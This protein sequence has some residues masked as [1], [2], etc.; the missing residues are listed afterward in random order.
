MQ[1]WLR[2]NNSENGPYTKEA[3]I[4]HGLQTSDL[5]RLDGESIWKPL[6]QFHELQGAI[7]NSPK[8]KYKFTADKQL[9]EIKGDP[10]EGQNLKE[11]TPDKA[12]DKSPDKTP[13]SGAAN[14]NPAHT[15]SAPGGNSPFK[16]MP[17]A[18][19]KKKVVVP[20]A[21]D[22]T[23]VNATEK[24]KERA[25]L[26][27]TGKIATAEPT[28][29]AVAPTT[30]TATHMQGPTSN[31]NHP[32]IQS[33]VQSLEEAPLR[34]VRH[35]P[36][37]KPVRTNAKPQNS[38]FFKE[39]FLP[40]IIIG[41]LGFLAWWGYKQFTSPTGLMV[42]QGAV[43]SGRLATAGPQQPAD[44]QNGVLPQ[45]AQGP[46]AIPVTHSKSNQA[47]PNAADS[48]L[49]ATSAKA[50]SADS[51]QSPKTTSQ[52]SAK[53]AATAAPVIQ[54]AENKKQTEQTADA[55]EQKTAKATPDDKTSVQQQNEKADSPKVI[56]A[57]KPIEKKAAPKQSTKRTAGISDYVG[58]SLNKTPEPGIKNVK[59]KVH[60]TSKEDLNIAVVEVKYFD[61]DGKF[62]QGETLQ[63]GKIGAGKS[64]TLK[65]P[66]SKN[67]EKISYK[68]SLISGDNVYLMG[69]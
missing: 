4:S 14:P 56:P 18:L 61:K 41:V 6:D 10:K 58:L 17:S 62:I 16:R 57:A 28:A 29:P 33:R 12:P 3:L 53:N 24:A 25:K 5:I 48:A 65:V 21:A 38:H 9:I 59:I 51:G 50:A 8:P 30:G 26:M 1:Y 35:K 68:V 49:R 40:V 34:E 46:A 67:A 66:S 63:T 54:P 15:G 20:P 64:V 42:G 31:T 60:N 23:E 7:Q 43:D 44:T 11:K 45:A 52:P 27:A 39:F 47:A 37:P 55:L 22:H 2:R 32:K 69:R 13:Q 19:P 36:T